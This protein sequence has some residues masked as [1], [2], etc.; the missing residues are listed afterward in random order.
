[1]FTTL[2]FNPA[3]AQ[4]RLED[5]NFG[6]GASGSGTYLVGA[7]GYHLGQDAKAQNPETGFRLRNAMHF[8]SGAVVQIGYGRKFAHS[9]FRMQL[10][11]TYFQSKLSD[12]AWKASGTTHN[13]FTAVTAYY[14]FMPEATITPF[15]GVGVGV[16]TPITNGTLDDTATSTK[17][18]TQDIAVMGAKAVA[19]VSAKLSEKIDVSLEYAYLY[20]SDYHIRVTVEGLGERF[21]KTNLEDHIFTAGMRYSF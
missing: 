18:S 16:L 14:D 3:K 7:A 15:L 21:T 12:N 8:D 9:N 6:F 13:F 11:L 17:L 19:G 1:M 10:D 5:P 4:D 20:S 2:F